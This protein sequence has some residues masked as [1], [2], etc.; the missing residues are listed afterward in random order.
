MIKRALES[1]INARF[2]KGKAIHLIGSRQV[3]KTTL[4]NK[5]LE[6]REH[7]FLNGDDPTVRK[8]LTNPNI[9]QLKN[10]IGNHTVVFIDEAQRI[11]NIGLTLKLSTDQLKAVQLLVNGFSAFELNNQTQ[12]PPTG[13]KWEYQLYP[14][15]WTEF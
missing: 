14:I 15:S 1:Q 13:R 2:G 5:L 10:I 8:L 12:E 7:L 9:E 6:N 3:G 11:D 4:L